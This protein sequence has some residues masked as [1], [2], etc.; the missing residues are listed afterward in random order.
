MH[1]APAER[2]PA[3]RHRR[4]ADRQAGARHH[5]RPP[6]DHARSRGPPRRRHP[7]RASSAGTATCMR[8]ASASHRSALHLVPNGVDT[9][10]FAPGAPRSGAPARALR[11]RRRRAAGRL[12]RPAVA[13]EGSRRLRARRAAAVHA[14]CPTRISC[15]SATGRC[16]GSCEA[17]RRPASASSGCVH[18]AGTQPRHAARCYG[19][20][21]VLV[22]LVALRGDAAGRDGGDGQRPA[23]RGDAASAASPT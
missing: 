4:Q 13:R 5:P 16:A 21:D 9:D 15:W 12:R 3:G 1:V 6:A 7:P 23:G 8:S 11:H 19:E 2:A 22:S 14:S 10:V 18:L 20:L 17:L